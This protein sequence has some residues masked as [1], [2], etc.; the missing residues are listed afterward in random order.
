MEL[1][2]AG[3]EVDSG[4]EI[5]P[6]QRDGG[7]IGLRGE[8]GVTH[9]AVPDLAAKNSALRQFNERV[10]VNTPIQGSSA[11]IIKQAMVNINI[12][13]KPWKSLP[14]LQVHDELLFECPVAEVDA[15]GAW[16]RHEME[17]AV[18]LSVPLVVDLKIGENWQDM[19]R[20]V[21]DS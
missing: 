19:K 15:F 21:R 1:R 5:E 17:S 6:G 3:E 16:A 8:N 14:L 10:A 20:V 7:A 4:C 12:K 13:L 2:K 9:I 18:K 11:D